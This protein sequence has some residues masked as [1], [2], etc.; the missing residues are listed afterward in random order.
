[1]SRLY[2][3]AKAAFLTQHGKESVIRENLAAPLGVELVHTDAFD[4][5]QLGTFTRTRPRQQS[6]LETARF[7]ARMAMELTGARIGL[8]SE[9]S[10]GS[11]PLGDWV[12][13]NLEIL[14]W[15][16]ADR[17][18]EVVGRASGPAH[19]GH[20]L[21]GHL[22]DAMEWARTQDFPDQALVI[23]PERDDHPWFIKGV[24]NWHDLRV[25]FADCQKRAE[26]D[27]VFLE[28][29][30]RAHCS[31]KRMVRIG[32][33]AADLRKRLA[34]ACPRCKGAGF[35]IHDRVRGLPCRQCHLKTKQTAATI[36]MCPGCG[37]QERR[38]EPYS[39]AEPLYCEYCN[40]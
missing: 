8:G 29:D 15:L 16:D 4:T 7:K 21:T 9:G 17:D 20:C 1:M 35:G 28:T 27:A 2:S 33:A 3:G 18:L 6:P 30:L 19:Q 14:V 37:F 26:T 12:P 13:W 31:P 32:E 10:F 36:W 5:D 11:G 23:R 24:T 39:H 34:C 22:E 40:P 25:A 38:P